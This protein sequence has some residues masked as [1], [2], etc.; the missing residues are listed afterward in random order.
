[1]LPEGTYTA[2]IPSG[3]N[4][5]PGE[6][7]LTVTT[8]GLGFTHPYGHRFSAGSIEEISATEIVLAPDPEC[9]VQ[10]GTPTNGRYRWSVEGAL[11]TFEVI[12]DSC[13]DRIDTLTSSEWSLR[14]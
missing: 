10:E 6:W 9:P 8:N 11:L 5:A 3:V 13:R 7:T 2:T 4:A 12:S 1:M 14:Q